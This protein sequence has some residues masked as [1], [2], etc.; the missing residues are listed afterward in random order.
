MT[1]ITEVESYQSQL[2]GLLQQ[3]P[4]M[5]PEDK[6]AVFHHDADEMGAAYT[7]TL[8][9]KTGDKAPDF[10]L[11]NAK[12]EQV[13][14]SALLKQGKVVLTFYRGVWCPYCNL[15]L[16]LYQQILPQI[17]RAGARL[18]AVSPMSPDNSQ[19]MIDGN[20]LQF[21]VLSDAGNKVAQGYTR[22]IQNPKSSI[23][24]MADLGYDFY[25]FNQE[26]SDDLPIPATFI[27]AENGSVLFAA[28]E[29]G[30]YRQ[31]V[32]PGDILQHL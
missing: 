13:A 8:K 22:V 29:G 16:K 25:G 31:R 30:D 1:V 27:I 3:L 11:P 18:V 17:R 15:Q 2:E 14:L 10:S 19:A 24:A 28:S 12:G 9:L 20:A 21:D 26:K 7:E 23:Q 5:L 4:T 32:E 6:L